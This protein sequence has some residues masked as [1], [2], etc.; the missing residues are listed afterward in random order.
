MRDRTILSMIFV[1]LLLSSPLWF[2]SPASPV[3]AL[4]NK[5]TRAAGETLLV[6]NQTVVIDKTSSQ[7][8]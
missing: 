5:N 3:L 8:Q 6:D 2:G 1:V 7:E 4:D